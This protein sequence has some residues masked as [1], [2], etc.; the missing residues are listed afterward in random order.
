VEFKINKIV[1]DAFSKLK[2][3]DEKDQFVKEYRAWA[4]GRFAQMWMESLAKD[5]DH[6]VKESEKLDSAS[7]FEFQMKEIK[8]RSQRAMLR[9]IIKELTL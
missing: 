4:N 2:T 8:Q 1:R 5:L 3:K 6:L 7:E 9:Q